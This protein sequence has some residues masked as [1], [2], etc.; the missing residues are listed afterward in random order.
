MRRFVLI[1]VFLGACDSP[2]IAF[3]DGVHGTA[4]AGGS[5]FGIHVKGDRVE[6]Y[7]VSREWRPRL[8]EV[9]V[10][11]VTAIEGLTGCAVKPGSVDGDQAIIRARLRC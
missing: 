1:L 10:R 2:S 3:R 9:R 4:E 6:A 11:A 5:R 8:D 7:R